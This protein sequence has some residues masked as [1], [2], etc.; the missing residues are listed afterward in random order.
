[1]LSRDKMLFESYN[2]RMSSLRESLINVMVDIKKTVILFVIHHTYHCHAKIEKVKHRK[3]D[4]IID[5]CCILIHIY[6]YLYLSIYLSIYL[7]MCNIYIYLQYIHI[8][9]I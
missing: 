8:Y 6:L 4:I 5:A 9:A 3:G 2:C 1:M 7:S